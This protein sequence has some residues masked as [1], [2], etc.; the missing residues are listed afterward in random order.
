MLKDSI[1]ENVDAS[2]MATILWE[3]SLHWSNEDMK[4]VLA[5]LNNPSQIAEWIGWTPLHYCV[6]F[7]DYISAR[8]L[9]QQSAKIHSTA[10]EPY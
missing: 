4:A 10:F 5:D 6:W 8:S 1:R 7:Q 3:T 9:V 2:E